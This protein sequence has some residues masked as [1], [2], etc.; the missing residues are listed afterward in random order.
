MIFPQNMLWQY[1]DRTLLR[2]LNT[3]QHSFD[4]VESFDSYKYGQASA[5]DPVTT[6]ER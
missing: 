6:G 2:L 1:G 3:V 5:P 4:I